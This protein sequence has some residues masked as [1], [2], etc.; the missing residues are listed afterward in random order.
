MNRTVLITGGSRGIGAAAVRAFYESGYST[1]FCYA[2]SAERAKK[3]ADE[4]PGVLA[5]QADVSDENDVHR[6]G[7]TFREAFGEPDVL[8]NNAGISMLKLLHDTTP[9]EWDTIF[10]VNCKGTYLCCREFLPGMIKRQSG[11]IINCSSIWGQRG[12]SYESAYA[13]SKAAVI[14]LSLSLAKELG[15]SGIR[16]NCIAPGVIETEMLDPFGPED[17]SVLCQQTPIG[18]L[19]NPQDVAKAMLFLASKDAS[20]ITGE[21]LGVTG[22]FGF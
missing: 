1:A 7:E 2:S 5:I 18:R 12:A 8:V 9:E 13:A 3:L 14:G 4:L 20:F 6:M 17:L 19:G 21:V 16:V 10:G 22:G 11:A 15:P